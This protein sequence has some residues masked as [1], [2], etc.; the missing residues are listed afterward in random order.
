MIGD[1]L[2]GI[3]G[4]AIIGIIARLVMPGKQN[5]TMVMTV[6]LGI[7]AGVLAGFVSNWLG[8]KHTPGV[9]WI[10]HA[11]QLVIAAGLIW[12]VLRVRGSRKGLTNATR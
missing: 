10:R 9:D 11:L 3:I 5:I 12:T 2:W 4:G 1:I 6:I 8:V 7:I